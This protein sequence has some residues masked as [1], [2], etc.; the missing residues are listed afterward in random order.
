[1]WGNRW[2]NKQIMVYL[3]VKTWILTDPTWR[4]LRHIVMTENSRQHLCICLIL[5]ASV[6]VLCCLRRLASQCFSRLCC[7]L[8]QFW[9]SLQIFFYW[10][11]H[12]GLWDMQGSEGYMYTAFKNGQT[13]EPLQAAFIRGLDSDMTGCLP[14]SEYCMSRQHLLRFRHSMCVCISKVKTRICREEQPLS[15]SFGVCQ[16]LEGAPE[17]VQNERVNM[18]HS[19]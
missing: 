2:S 12:R 11:G 1:M 4:T 6:S 18:E 5:T 13:E 19:L 9:C 15:N 17:R 16:T 8:C 14:A 3:I 10:H 7:P